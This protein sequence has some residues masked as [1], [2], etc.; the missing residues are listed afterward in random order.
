MLAL[1]KVTRL[2]NRFS[3]HHNI[4]RELRVVVLPI[5]PAVIRFALFH[6]DF[7]N[8]FEYLYN[9]I[10]FYNVIIY[11]IVHSAIHFQGGNIMK[12][13]IEMVYE[14]AGGTSVLTGMQDDICKLS[15]GTDGGI[16]K[17]ELHTAEEIRIKKFR[18]ILPYRFSQNSRIFANG[19][20]SWT[21]S[22]EYMPY[23]KM[24][25]LSRPVELFINSPLAAGTGLNR[26][27]DGTFHKYPR[28]KGVFYG[29]SYGYVRDGE[30]TELF[31]SIS[32]RTG[33]TIITFDTNK[34]LICIEKDLAGKTFKESSELLSFAVI[35]G[36]YEAVFNKYFD[37]MKIPAP[38]A[39]RACGYTTWYNYYGNVTE[40]VVNRDLESMSKCNINI[41]FFQIDDGYQNAIGDWLITD[42]VKFPSGMKAVADAI[43]SRGIK[44]G[45][46]LAPFAGVKKSALFQNH[47]DWF[48]TDQTGKHYITG[49][50]WGTFYALDI[51]NEDA[52][53]YIK[54][55][56]D[57]VLNEWGYD[58]VKLDFLYAAAVLPIHGKTRGEIM[59]DAMDLLRA[60]CGEKLILGCGV[61]LM[62]AFGKVDYCRIGADVTNHWV[63]RKFTT[64]EDVSTPHGVNNSIFRR[65]LDGR[66]FMND[67][68]V[69]FLRNENMKMDFKKRTLLAKIDSLFGSLLFVSDNVGNYDAEQMRA[70][71]DVFTSQKADIL[72]AEYTAKKQITVKYRLNDT[73][74]TLVFNPDN[75]NIFEEN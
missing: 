72:S 36:D 60:C 70:L 39:K 12:Y 37:L 26:S 54:K 65:H 11:I 74:H 46:W 68:D 17:I 51:Y 27:G 3:D 52:R 7:P 67:P 45:L 38:R 25:E 71:K 63:P 44:A 61:P 23:E 66:A 56:F 40:E 24:S 30:R 55:V 34:N 53:N 2:T 14:S 1:H 42:K 19:F 35:A 73:E 62:P 4:Y 15:S 29:F 8:F 20:Q 16:T 33:Y 75:G 22:R 31:G 9:F 6:V 48:I 18:L 28:K 47:P 10:P 57:T 41:D 13:K 69:F 21:D 32:E 43:H 5:C 58:L 64:R 59:C 49:P 50:N